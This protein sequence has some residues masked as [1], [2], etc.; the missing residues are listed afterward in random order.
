MPAHGEREFR[1]DLQ[2]G[3]LAQDFARARCGECGQ[4]FLVAYSCKWRGVCSSC[5]TRC[6]V[7]TAAHLADHAFLRMPVRQWVLAMQERYRIRRTR[8]PAGHRY[9]GPQN[10]GPSSIHAMSRMRASSAASRTYRCRDR[11]T[12]SPGQ[13][14]R[15]T[16]SATGGA[17][18]RPTYGF[19]VP[20]A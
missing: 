1:R 14:N 9:S 17:A 10:T 6:K 12:T 4:D 20:A 19:Q 15:M 18:S 5:N 3:I 13:K 8:V 7:E 11:E 16:G 2:C